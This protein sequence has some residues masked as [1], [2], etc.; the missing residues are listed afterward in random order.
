MELFR[1]VK[2]YLSAQEYASLDKRNREYVVEGGEVLRAPTHD[3]SGRELPDPVPLA[4]PV[5]YVP[6]QSM[7]EVMRDMIRGEHLKAY[8]AAQGSE[9]F[10][11]AQDFDVED[12]MF[13]Q[14][15]FE[16]DFEPMEDL[17]ARRDREF[18]RRFVEEEKDAS[19]LAWRDKVLAEKESQLAGLA[20][21]ARDASREPQASRHE[22]EAPKGRGRGKQEP[23][24]ADEAD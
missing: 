18:R 24:P 11:E 16:G 4:P 2:R 15:S 23:G 17:Q 9:N 19:Y 21:M 3:E 7:F 14:S 12:D 8:A 1:R 6:H 22:R 5:G 13:P 10:E 20:R